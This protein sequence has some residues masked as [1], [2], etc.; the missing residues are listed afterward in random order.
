[1]AGAGAGII[2]ANHV[3]NF[4][5]VAVILLLI[6]LRLRICEGERWRKTGNPVKKVG[7]ASETVDVD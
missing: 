4:D 7:G 3:I 2:S 6:M 1:M 5:D